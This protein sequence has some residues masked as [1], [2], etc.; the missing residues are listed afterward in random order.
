[1]IW[2]VEEDFG[3][4]DKEKLELVEPEGIKERKILG[5]AMLSFLRK[6]NLVGLLARTY[7]T[8]FI[9]NRS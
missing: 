8:T 9:C 2:E 7:E 5:E 6:P 3:L 4:R 1:M